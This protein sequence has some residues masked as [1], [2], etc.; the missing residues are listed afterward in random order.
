MESGTGYATILESGT[1]YFW[2]NKEV[3]N[4]LPDRYVCVDHSLVTY[5][6]VRLAVK[7][8]ALESYKDGLSLV[9]SSA[10]ALLWMEAK[11]GSVEDGCIQG[12][13]QDVKASLS[14]LA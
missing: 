1:G 5:Q 7:G 12:C 4:F 10:K 11:G 13:I 9:F 14:I 8:V 2:P 3:P 6:F